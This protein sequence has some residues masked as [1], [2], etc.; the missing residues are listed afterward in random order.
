MYHFQDIEALKKRFRKVE[1]ES[2]VV[3]LDNIYE[4]MIE[5]V[6]DKNFYQKNMFE[7]LVSQEEE[8]R[9]KKKDVDVDIDVDVDVTGRGGGEE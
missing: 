1:D 3:K 5:Q 7:K 4:K 8:K 2:S 6:R 9:S